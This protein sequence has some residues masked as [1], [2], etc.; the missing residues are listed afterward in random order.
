MDLYRHVQ[1]GEQLDTLIQEGY[2]DIE[3]LNSFH[4]LTDHD[5][6]TLFKVHLPRKAQR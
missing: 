6:A 3:F 5:L 2:R 1:P 4:L